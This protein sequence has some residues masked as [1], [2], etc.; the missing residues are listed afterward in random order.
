MRSCLKES[1]RQNVPSL[2][3]RVEEMEKAPTLVL[4]IW[5]VWGMVRELGV[6][7]VEEELSERAERRTQWPNCPRCGKK[8]RSKGFEKRQMVSLLG[9]IHW[10]RRV[11]RC[12]EG[13]HRGQVAPLDEE[14]GLV[15]HERTS[16]ELKQIGSEW[17]IFV[18]YETVVRLLSKLIGVGIS[19]GSV[20]HWVQSA[21][22][23]AMQRVNREVEELDLGQA[24]KEEK[25]EESVVKM[26]LL[27]GADGVMVG[28][29]PER[30]KVK[31]K[32]VWREIKV[33]ILA[34]L[35]RRISRK[36]KEVTRLERRRLVAVLGDIDALSP[37]LWIEAVGQGILHAKQVI[38]LSDGGRGFWG[39]YFARFAG[40]AQGIL[41]FYHAAQNLWK[42]ASAWL[43][44]RSRQA[45]RWFILARH[46]LRHGKGDQVLAGLANAMA[47]DGIP[48]STRKTLSNVYEYL[49]RHRDHIE[50]EKFKELG[51]PIG[52]G[53]VESACKWLIQQRFKGVG[54]R[55]S[56]DGFNHLL[57]LRLAWVNGRF[58][59][60]FSPQASPNL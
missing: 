4:M 41:D 44:G 40:Y 39:W 3:G 15:P 13:C 33:G 58:D 10:R 2:Q 17:G 24:P 51:L 50:Y 7:L 9:V 8:L 34:R 11:G 42:G 16:P 43:D 25:L 1:I 35:G 27:I 30:G 38:W 59:T 48:E 55:W 36:G 60:L 47:L 49:Q 46:H 14:L 32:T 45:R 23:R 37:R 52:S 29:R 57:H 53:L 19:A 56:E 21:G 20:W 54:M 18:P 31:G 5:A 22:E 26:P 28:F 12:R 6:K